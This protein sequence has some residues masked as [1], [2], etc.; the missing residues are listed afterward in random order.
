MVLIGDKIDLRKIIEN[1]KELENLLQ[2]PIEI[3]LIKESANLIFRVKGGK[4]INAKLE[5]TGWGKYE[6][7]TLKMLKNKGYNVPEPISFI[8]L[9]EQLNANMNF[10]ELERE[11]GILFYYPIEGKGLE[12]DLRKINIRNALS[13]LKKLHEDKSLVDGDIQNYQEI[14]VGRGLKYIKRLFEGKLAEEIREVMKKY[15]NIKINSCFIHG[16]PR[17]EH[18]I[19][20]NDRIGMIDFEGA[21]IGDP[22]KD[23]GIFLTELLCYN[24]KTDGLIKYYFKRELNDQEKFRLKFFKLRALLVKKNFEPSLK[25]LDYIE[26]T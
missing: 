23:L 18:F 1:S 20:N 2:E 12:K 24:E 25:V 15:R 19:I 21:C 17:L 6:F 7:Q 5:L 4:E 11:V 16:G 10:G 14:E 9:Q 3:D 8:P 13:F 22:F 26:E